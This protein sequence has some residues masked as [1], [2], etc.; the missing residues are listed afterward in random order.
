M[1]GLEI[2]RSN[3]S[4]IRKWHLL[5]SMIG[6]AQLYQLACRPGPR[7]FKLF[8]EAEAS[9]FLQTVWNRM[10]P[11]STEVITKT[12]KENTPKLPPCL[13]QLSNRKG[14]WQYAYLSTCCRDVNPQNKWAG[15]VGLVSGCQFQETQACLSWAQVPGQLTRF[16]GISAVSWL[17]IK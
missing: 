9:L 1:P 7:C 2:V 11:K 10:K 4:F 5:I 12:Q 17:E 14:S 3:L 16:S 13:L 8:Q 6:W 15:N